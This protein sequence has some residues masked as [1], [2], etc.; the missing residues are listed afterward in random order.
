M[1][2]RSHSGCSSG[3]SATLR[4]GS[5]S[6]RCVGASPRAPALC[7]VLLSVSPL[8]LLLLLRTDA[9]LLQRLGANASEGRLVGRPVATHCAGRLGRA[10]GPGHLQGLGQLTDLLPRARAA[11][12]EVDRPPV[13]C[14]PPAGYRCPHWKGRF[15]GLPW[16]EGSARP[17]WRDRSLVDSRSRALG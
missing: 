7:P 8:Q 16:T 5:P 14:W 9:L 17:S 2:R 11:R 6:C 13:W 4:L 15:A 1:A 10:L 3:H 12:M